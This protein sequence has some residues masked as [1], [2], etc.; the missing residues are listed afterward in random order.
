MAFKRL[1]D[2]AMPESVPRWWR[3][4]FW[5]ENYKLNPH[6]RYN[7][8]QCLEWQGNIKTA[9][10]PR[11][12]FQN[13]GYAAH[14]MAYWLHNGVDPGDLLV[15]HLCSNRMC[16][17][18]EHLA[19]G[20]HWENSQDMVQAGRSLKGKEHW[21]KK[22][23]ERLQ[24]LKD[25]GV[26]ATQIANLKALNGEN[27]PRTQLTAHIVRQIKIRS[28]QGA[29]N[30]ELA[31]MF[32]VTHSNIS[33]IV[34][35]KSWAHIEAPTREADDRYSQK[36]TAADVKEI[37][38]RYKNGESRASIARAFNIG[39]T[40]IFKIVNYQSWKHVKDDE[41]DGQS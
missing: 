3:M 16:A 4:W 9:M 35:G 10:Y 32:N 13:Q 29:T 17:R 36:L 23:P 20:T 1:S 40:A 25:A 33:A 34:L 28:S 37:R 2:L 14:R 19:L 18:Q 6:K 38:R 39:S 41:T 21:T 5:D 8:L 26:Y 24:E 27:H 11:V 22:Y 12:S 30:K 15:R 7:G 31:K